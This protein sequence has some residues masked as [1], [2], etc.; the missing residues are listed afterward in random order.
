MKFSCKAG[1]GSAC[2]HILA[3]LFYCSRYDLEDLN[4][5]SCTD[6]K[7]MWNKPQKSSLEKYKPQPL[8]EHDCVLIKRMKNFEKQ[9]KEKKDCEKSILSQTGEYR[10]E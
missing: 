9:S 1:L 10:S 6:K 8:Q 7:C 4:I 2:K 5:V 3:I